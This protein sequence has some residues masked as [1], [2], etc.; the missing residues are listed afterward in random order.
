M[1]LKMLPVTSSDGDF[2]LSLYAS[3]RVEELAL[4][5]WSDEQKQEFVKF[6][7][8]AQTRHYAE[9]Y[10]PDSFRII[11]VDGKKIGRLYLC[12]LP[13]ELRIIDLTISPEFRGNGVGS[14]IIAEI[15]ANSVKPVRIYLESFNRSARLFE[16]LGFK[17]I[18]DEG[19][20]RLWESARN[21][22]S[23]TAG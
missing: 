20:Y 21:G 16:R 2:L 6:Q 10:P 3:T 12:E 23:G 13:D 4:V 17:P 19:I 18:R 9:R 5:P 11:E 15:L 8:D 7:F 1:T 22:E 14:S